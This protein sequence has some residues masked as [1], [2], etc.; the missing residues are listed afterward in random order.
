MHNVNS[1]ITKNLIKKINFFQNVM[2][3]TFILKFKIMRE[4]LFKI[5]V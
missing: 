3:L 5:I 4:I 2:S 1:I